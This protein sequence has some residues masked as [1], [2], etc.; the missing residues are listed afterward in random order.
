MLA[1]PTRVVLRVPLTRHQLGVVAVLAD[2]HGLEE[3]ARLLGVERSTVDYHVY[4]A[5]R[6]IGGDLPRVARCIAWYRGASL[7]VLGATGVTP[8]PRQQTLLTALAI[9]E[10][11]G[12]RRCGYTGAQE[13]VAHDAAAQQARPDA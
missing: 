4:K 3:A 9:A 13:V 6:R 5:A 8:S 11:R 1:D 2:G 7:E 12:C 10:G